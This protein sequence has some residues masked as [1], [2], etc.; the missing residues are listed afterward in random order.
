VE[1]VKRYGLVFKEDGYD[2]GE[3]KDGGLVRYSDYQKVKELLDEQ[4]ELIKSI[5]FNLIGPDKQIQS[6]KTALIYN[7]KNVIDRIDNY[8]KKI[9]PSP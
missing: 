7:I 3:F 6:D 1:E 9:T 2:L 8:F 5:K 4:T